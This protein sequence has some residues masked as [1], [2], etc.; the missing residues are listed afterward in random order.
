MA[1]DEDTSG[2]VKKDKNLEI[3]DRSMTSVKPTSIERILSN[4]R[5]KGNLDMKY[6][7]EQENMKDVIKR[8]QDT[9]KKNCF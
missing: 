2:K 8:K 3:G 9:K 4:H 7:M 1:A 6:D 5:N